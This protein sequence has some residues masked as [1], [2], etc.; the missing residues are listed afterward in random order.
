MG[1]G[2]PVARRPRAIRPRRR[3][4]SA[5]AYAGRRGPRALV[6]RGTGPGGEHQT[7]G[8]AGGVVEKRGERR[9]RSRSFSATDTARSASPARP[10]AGT[11]WFTACASIRMRTSFPS[12]GALTPVARRSPRQAS[13]A[14]WFQTKKSNSEIRAMVGRSSGPSLRSGVAGGVTARAIPPSRMARDAWLRAKH[15]NRST[16]SSR[17]RGGWPYPSVAAVRKAGYGLDSPMNPADIGR[18]GVSR[19]PDSIS[20]EGHRRPLVQVT[21]SVR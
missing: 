19:T 9:L 10:A 3:S 6:H 14:I 21:T 17:T 8:R 20:A 13:V 1:R 16:P 18:S 4:S 2:T 11:N 7:G 15:V 12:E 5:R